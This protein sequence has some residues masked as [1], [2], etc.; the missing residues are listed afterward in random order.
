MGGGVE[1][2]TRTSGKIAQAERAHTSGLNPE[3]PAEKD[4]QTGMLDGSGDPAVR[5]RHQ[6]VQAAAA[7]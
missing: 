2:R 3:V 5:N 1:K 4:P 6:P 7:R